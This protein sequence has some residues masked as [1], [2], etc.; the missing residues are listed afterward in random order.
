MEHNLTIQVTLRALPHRRLVQAAGKRNA[1]ELLQRMLAPRQVST[2]EPLVPKLKRYHGRMELTWPD[3]DKH[4]LTAGCSQMD[5]QVAFGASLKVSRHR[6]SVSYD[7]KCIQSTSGTDWLELRPCC[8]ARLKALKQLISDGVIG[9]VY[10]DIKHVVITD[11]SCRSLQDCLDAHTGFHL[12]L[13]RAVRSWTWIHLATGGVFEEC[14]G[15]SY[16]QHVEDRQEDRQE[17]RKT[18]GRYRRPTFAVEHHRSPSQRKM[19]SNARSIRLRQTLA[20]IIHSLTGWQGDV[21]NPDFIVCI[22]TRGALLTMSLRF[23]STFHSSEAR[24]WSES[25]LMSGWGWVQEFFSTTESRELSH[26]DEACRKHL[27]EAVRRRMHHMRAAVVAA[28]QMRR[29]WA[30]VSCL[31]S[32]SVYSEFGTHELRSH[33]LVF[34][35][36]STLVR[37][38]CQKHRRAL[39]SPEFCPAPQLDVHCIKHVTNP[40]LAKQYLAR[41]EDVQ[42]LR[43]SGCAPIKGLRHLKIGS[44]K[45]GNPMELELNEHFL[46]HGATG[47]TVQGILRGGFDPR[48]GGEGVGKLFGV[49]TYFTPHASKA[50]IYTEQHSNRLPRHAQRELIVARCVLGEVHCTKRAMRDASRP[51]DGPENN[52]LDSVI[53]ADRA[54]GGVVDH[55]EVMIYDKGQAVPEFVVV[56]SHARSCLCAECMKR[57]L[58]GTA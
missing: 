11:W 53:A 49:A 3:M 37:S 41:V 42:G 5:M 7:Q 22:R 47:A 45:G 14:P 19:W 28:E 50:D 12:A 18:A 1:V 29:A 44:R 23:P 36:I 31:P 25:G 27:Q 55:T 56:Y 2:P 6:R 57:P 32:P 33:D 38:S 4:V 10:V 20:D 40:R 9:N 15:V 35:L 21:V 26:V 16:F 8:V 48:R 24:N 34:K 43:P 46:F 39:H 58:A 52:P 51:P 13:C 54:S 30:Q 17:G